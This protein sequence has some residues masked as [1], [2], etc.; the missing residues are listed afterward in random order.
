[1]PDGT[2]FAYKNKNDAEPTGS[3]ITPNEKSKGSDIGS[4]SKSIIHDS[5][6]IINLFS[7]K[8]SEVNKNGKRRYHRL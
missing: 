4:A 5:A 1:M 3:G 6:E 8:I 7:K 2:G